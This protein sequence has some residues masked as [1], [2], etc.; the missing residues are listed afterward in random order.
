MAQIFINVLGVLFFLPFISPYADLVGRTSPSLPRQIANAH[1]I[2][3]VVVSTAMFPFVKQIAWVA[4][5]L[6]PREQKQEKEKLT[7]FIDEMQYSVPAVAL[8]EAAREMS[9]LG[10]MTSR[11][12]DASCQ[13]LLAKNPE[14]A[15]QVLEQEEKYVD[16]IYKILVEFVNRLL[17]EDL[18]V[19]Q[20]KR[21][22]QIKNLLIDI[23]RV[24]DMAEDIS[25]YAMERIRNDVPFSPQ[26]T[27][28]LENLSSHT[29]CTFSSAIQ[30]FQ[31]NDKVLARRVCDMESEF[32]KLYWQTRQRHIDRLDAGLCTPE[33]NVIFTETLRTL[34]RISDHADN[35]GVSVMRA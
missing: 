25:Q 20:Q 34:E 13:A 31:D 5:R 23:E 8:R 7:V 3:N 26:A 19:T 16:P 28:E 14:L 1:T 2:F 22:F 15:N 17:Q 30:A 11:M 21:C 35:L 29:L 18:S 24:S 10:D 12:L 32:D 4:E 6:V 33:A 27:R 9:R